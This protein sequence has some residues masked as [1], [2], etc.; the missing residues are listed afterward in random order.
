M[1]LQNLLIAL[2]ASMI[3]NVLIFV[4]L[5]FVNGFFFSSALSYVYSSTSLGVRNLIMAL[6]IALP[7][8]VVFAWCYRETGPV[9]AGMAQIST[10]T[11]VIMANSALLGHALSGRAWLAAAAL[12]VAAAWFGWEVSQA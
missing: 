9:L 10:L 6:L 5:A 2:T 7:A 8:N 4:G 3:G 12:L 11:L 1:P